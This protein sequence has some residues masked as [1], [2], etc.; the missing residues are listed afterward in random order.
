MYEEHVGL[1][2][3]EIL[4]KFLAISNNDICNTSCAYLVT[5]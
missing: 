5:F 4:E 1:K 2:C 3:W